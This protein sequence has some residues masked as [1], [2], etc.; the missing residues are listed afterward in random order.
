MEEKMAQKLAQH[1]A[2]LK[3]LSPEETKR[4]ME[5]AR[6]AILLDP[7]FFDAPLSDIG[8]SDAMECKRRLKGLFEQF[9]PPTRAIV[10]PLQRTLQTAAIIFESADDTNIEVAEQVRERLTGRP[11]DNRHATITV[12]QRES[13]RK[14]DFSRV[15]LLSNM[16]EIQ[17]ALKDQMKHL[18]VLEGSDKQTE[19]RSSSGRRYGRTSS[20]NADP[21][22]AETEEDLAKRTSQLLPLLLEKEDTNVA[23]VSHK[24]YLRSLECTQ[25]G[26]ENPCNFNNGEIRVYRIVISKNH[27]TDPKIITAKRL[28]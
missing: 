24:G 7:S 13:F 2:K 5:E 8:R 11:A 26:V 16:A 6:Q 3:G 9:S 23:I 19:V 18:T 1:E 22:S 25:F 4:R 27:G 17:E 12:A 10:S 15:R 21:T 20:S 14:M 28:C